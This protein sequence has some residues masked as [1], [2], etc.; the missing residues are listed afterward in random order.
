MASPR[1]QFATRCCHVMAATP[2]AIRSGSVTRRRYCRPPSPPSCTSRSPIRGW[3]T[4]RIWCR[5]SPKT[6]VLCGGGRRLSAAPPLLDDAPASP[7][8][9][10]L[11][12]TPPALA[13]HP[14]FRRDTTLAAG[15][16][17]TWLPDAIARKIPS[18]AREPRWH[19]IFPAS[20][21]WHGKEGR[22]GRHHLH[23]TVTQR[24]VAE[25]ARVSGMT[26]ASPATPSGT[27]SPPISSNVATTSERSR[28]SSATATS[29]RP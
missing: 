6:R 26:S 29:Q 18:T 25:A 24:A 9:R 21:R 16:G 1:L 28:C 22:E 4:S 20:R 3:C 7:V 12:F 10:R 17:E 14:R 15:W 5:V 13:N 27:P 19:W 11:A 2:S 8:S 23:E